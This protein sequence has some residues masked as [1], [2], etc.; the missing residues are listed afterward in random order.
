MEDDVGEGPLVLRL[1]LHAVDAAVLAAAPADRLLGD[2]PGKVADAHHALLG[3]L[4]ER[5]VHGLG[6]AA[7][8]LVGAVP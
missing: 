2:D 3:A 7:N 1:H 5:P 6:D 8:V 4:L